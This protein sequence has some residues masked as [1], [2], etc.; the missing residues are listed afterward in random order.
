VRDHGK[1]SFCKIIGRLLSS[2]ICKAGVLSFHILLLRTGV[3][4]SIFLFCLNIFVFA[5]ETPIGVYSLV[6]GVVGSLLLFLGWHE[7]VSIVMSSY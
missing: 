5:R 3:V 2:V 4:L 7:G 1:I 6:F